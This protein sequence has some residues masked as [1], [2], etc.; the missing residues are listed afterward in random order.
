MHLATR[1]YSSNILDSVLSCLFVSVQVAVVVLAAVIHLYVYLSYLPFY[2]PFANQLH[3]VFA[4]IFAWGAGCL[5]FAYF[6][7]GSLVS[8]HSSALLRYY[9]DYCY[10]G[11]TGSGT[12]AE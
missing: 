9:E 5:A 2:S 1:P 6:A 12:W 11:A 3:C 7:T 10:I 8:H 4:T